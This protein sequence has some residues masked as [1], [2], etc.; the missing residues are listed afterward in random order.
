[1]WLQNLDEKM[2]LNQLLEHKADKT[3]AKNICARLT[4]LKSALGGRDCGNVGNFFK[5]VETFNMN[6]VDRPSNSDLNS[7]DQ[8]GYYAD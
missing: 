3:M 2:L 4:F 5:S 8:G 7:P 1:M 6:T